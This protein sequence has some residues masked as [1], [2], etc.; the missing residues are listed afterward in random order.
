MK[1]TLPILVC[2]FLLS[3]NT[4]LAQD[5]RQDRIG[6]GIGP[7]FMYGDNTGIHSKFKFKVLPALSIDYQKK[8]T[9]F[10]D[11]K[12]TL[13]WQMI[14]SGDHYSQELK[15]KI[16][17]AHLPH[18]FSGNVFFGDVMPIYHINPN[19]SG[20]IPSLIKVYTGLGLGYFYSKRTDERLILNDSRRRTESYPASDSGV[21]IPFRIGAFINLDSAADIGFEATFIYSPFSELEGNDLQ[22]KRI[23]ADMLMQF[24]FYY[25]IHLGYRY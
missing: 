14:N 13:G 6:I 9:P 3:L 16:A 19:L 2:I 8:L 7:S 4:A 18:A 12:G 20:Y 23:N 22:Q 15:D 11:V 17:E 5:D 1:S 25:R 10:F 21:Y 24:Q